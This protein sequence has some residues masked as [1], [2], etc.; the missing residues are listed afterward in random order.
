MSA[1]KSNELIQRASHDLDS[2]QLKFW[3]KVVDM[4]DSDAKSFKSLYNINLKDFIENDL[5]HKNNNNFEYVYKK[6]YEMRD[7]GF[8]IISKDVKELNSEQ[9]ELVSSLI[10]LKKI[11]I[12]EMTK[13]SKAP[14]YQVINFLK[15][16][17]LTKKFKEE[18]TLLEKNLIIPSDALKTTELYTGWFSSVEK[19]SISG[20]IEIEIP[21][22]MEKFYL[23]L[24]D[25]GNFSTINA[26]LVYKLQNKH[27]IRF[28]ELIYSHSFK[29]NQLKK[30]DKNNK[31]YIEI[32]IPYKKL[33]TMLKMPSIKYQTY[34]DFRRYVLNVAKKELKEKNTDIQFDFDL[35]GRGEGKTI[36]FKIYNMKNIQEEEQ[37]EKTKELSNTPDIVDKMQYDQ[38]YNYMTANFKLHEKKINELFSKHTLNELARAIQYV[39]EYSK[40]TK[41]G[42][43]TGLFLKTLETKDW[44]EEYKEKKEDKKIKNKQKELPNVVDQEVKKEKD[45]LDKQKEKL[46]TD[47]NL[48]QEFIKYIAETAKNKPS[49][50][51]SSILPEIMFDSNSIDSIPFIDKFIEKF[52]KVRD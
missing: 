6:L 14:L 26:K 13:L 9:K 21:K 1:N 46:K 47:P 48:Y 22:K 42:N 51:A 50:R 38:I 4:I 24:K 20:M 25:K 33:R 40:R 43:I 49:G 37:K 28:Y 2:I 19:T 3:Y 52:F 15:T 23:G 8:E 39:D 11:S 35:S 30:N 44:T 10:L 29:T 17:N 27:S 18:V 32:S 31:E 16:L 45:Q 7:K 41:V 36:I 12:E 34:T 5:K